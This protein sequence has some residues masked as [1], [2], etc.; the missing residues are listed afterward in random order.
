[1]R[2]YARINKSTLE[3]IRNQ[4][5]VSFEYVERNT[6]YDQQKVLSWEDPS[7]AKL[8]TINQAK[9]M[10]KCYHIPFAGLY[11]NQTD[12]N[13]RHLPRLRNMR[14]VV[15]AITD[16]SVVNLAVWDLVRAR[17]FFVETKAEFDEFI[18]AFSLGIENDDVLDW[19]RTI[20]TYF[21]LDLAKQYA[22]TSSRQFYLYLREQVERK[23]VFVQ[24]F[25]GVDTSICRGI[26]IAEGTMPIIGINANDRY[27]AK[28]FSILHELVHVIKRTSSVCNDMYGTFSSQ[29]EEVFCNAVAGEV[30]APRQAILRECGS[31]TPD[32]F[33]LDILDRIAK[34]F[35]VSS[36]V[37][38]RRLYDLGRLSFPRYSTLSRALD[39]RFLAEKE[40]LKEQRRASGNG[41][42]RNM[43]REAIDRT[44][45]EL[46]RVLLRGY[47]D[48]YFDKKDLSNHLDIG[49][50]HIDKFIMEVFKWYMR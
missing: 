4:L 44:S 21:D 6:H 10:A 8:P 3:F 17:D 46:C 37:I 13:V 43:S 36:E 40:A 14:T 48:G 20:R 30:L 2:V 45:S 23:G 32:E 7:S 31:Y 1:M 49:Q 12:I 15:D 16:E 22:S 29:Q 38:N 9:A 19:A 24:S 26:A 35:S 50:K 39:T 5:Q 41:I 28:S 34:K 42:P 47:S 33:T 18:P 11:M 25:S 27:P